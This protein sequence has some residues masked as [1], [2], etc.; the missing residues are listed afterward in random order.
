M[1]KLIM[2]VLLD[3]DADTMFGDDAEGRDWFFNDILGG[4]DLALWD[5]GEIG[6]QI[7]KVQVLIWDYAKPDAGMMGGLNE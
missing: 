2:M 1:S 5:H 7:G 3:Y 4:T 6:D